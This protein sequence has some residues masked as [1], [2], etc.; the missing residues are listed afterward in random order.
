MQENKWQLG[1]SALVSHP[2]SKNV[3]QQI[4]IF[5]S[6]GFESF[7]LS[8]GVSDAFEKIPAWSQCAQA[9]GIEFEAVHGP[10]YKVDSVWQG[11]ERA[12]L[13]EKNLFRILDYCSEGSVSKLVL[14][15]ATDP[16]TQVTQVGLDFW[17][18][19]EEYAQNRGVHLCY[20][21]ANTPQTLEAVVSAASDFHGFCFDVGHQLCHTPDK[22]YAAMFGDKLLFTHIHDN[23]SDG[24]DLHLLPGDGVN[25]WA[26]FM[27]SINA[28]GYR[29]TLN[30]ELSC[31]HRAAYRQMTFEEFVRHSYRR[32]F[33]VIK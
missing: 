11:G 20:E 28:V 1:M 6:V 18:K 4:E 16:Q 21:N 26:E 25:D 12:Q 24:Q 27:K 15:V 33:D 13:Y 30:L 32:I 23:F 17:K 3:E 31:Y 2:E 7:F 29:G 9:H 8:C 5:A 19:A 22:D 14:H 10:S